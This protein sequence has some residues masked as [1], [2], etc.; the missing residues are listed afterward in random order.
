MSLKDKPRVEWTEGSGVLREVRRGHLVR[1]T[2]TLS[3][4]KPDDRNTQVRGKHSK[5]RLL[6]PVEGWLSMRP[7]L[8]FLRINTYTGLA[9][10][11]I[12]ISQ[13]NESVIGIGPIPTGNSPFDHSDALHAELAA[14]ADWLAKR[15]T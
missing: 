10:M 8:R 4:V 14:I 1:R 12:T 5:F 9:G 11:G 15:P 2:K 3:I 7:R 6:T 13:T